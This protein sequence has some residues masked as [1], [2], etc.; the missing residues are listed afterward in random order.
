MIVAPQD[1]VINGP[2]EEKRGQAFDNLKQHMD[3]PNQTPGPAK[4]VRQAL[5]KN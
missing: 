2:E 5:T 3:K 1:H 4:P